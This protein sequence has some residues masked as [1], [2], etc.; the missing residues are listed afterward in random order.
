MLLE[1][2]SIG[3]AA[4]VAYS[5]YGGKTPGTVAESL[6][7][8][9]NNGYTF[10]NIT[11]ADSLDLSH[12]DVK[13]NQIIHSGLVASDRGMHGLKRGF[14]QLYNGTSEITQLYRTDNLYL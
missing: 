9:I 10:R 8:H 5:V 4:Y 1:A 7:A 3:V 12:P 14:M 11:Y 6:N 13:N 2:L